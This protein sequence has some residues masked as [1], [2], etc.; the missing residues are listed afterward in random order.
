LQDDDVCR[1]AIKLE[2]PIIAES[3]RHF[4]PGSRTAQLFCVGLFGTCGYPELDEWDVPLPSSKPAGRRPPPSGQKPLKVVHYSDIHIDPL[5]TEGANTECTKPICCRPYT[6]DDAPGHSLFPAGPNGD[7]RCDTPFNLEASMYAAIKKL[8]PDAAFTIF[9]GDIIDHAVW[10][11]SEPHVETQVEHAYAKMDE[12]LGIVYGTA[13]NHEAHPTNSFQPSSQGTESQWIYD[14]LAHEWSRWIDSNG[15]DDAYR[16]GSYSVKY[17][18]GNL[19]IISLN[20]NLWYRQ[21]YWLYRDPMLRDPDDQLQW[22]VRELDGAERAGENVYI[23]GHMSIGDRNAL[24]DG[25]N[26]LDQIINRYS[27]TIAAMFF[28]HTHRDEFQISYGNYSERGHGNAL[29]MSYIGPSLTPSSGMPS[30]RVYDVDPVTF[31]VLDVTQYMADMR[32][33]DF[34]TTGPVWKKFYSAKEVYGSAVEPPVTDPAAELTPGFWH[35]VTEAFEADDALFHDFLR[36]QSRGW[37]SPSCTGDCKTEQICQLR[38]ARSQNSCYKP[39]PGLPLQ[40]GE[41]VLYHDQNDECDASVTAAVLG[42]LARKEGLV[43]ELAL[44]LERLEG[45]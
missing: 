10:N 36:R 8:V 42:A 45:G 37:L 30:F 33:P 35:N 29:V 38:A 4:N 26:Y 14:L 27:S 19:R 43:E 31:G 34:Q 18:H 13:G 22:L 20:T 23:M 1:G 40:H 41:G 2:G 6:E 11:T 17:P 44:R 39:G 3:I 32:S 21:N 15:T 12:S 25:S 5:Y 16:R 24:H 7:H 28:G 9:T